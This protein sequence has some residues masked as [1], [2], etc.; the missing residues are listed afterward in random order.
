MKFSL[1]NY[2]HVRRVTNGFPTS[3]YGEKKHVAGIE[4]R[5][6]T[7]EFL[8]AQQVKELVLPLRQPGLLQWRRFDPWPGDLTYAEVEGGAGGIRK[9]KQKRNL[10][11]T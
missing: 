11:E 1:Q 6:V 10:R 8:V 9:T 2:F 4:I 5:N 7:E 3:Y